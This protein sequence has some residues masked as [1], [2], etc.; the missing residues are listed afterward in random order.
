MGG[1]GRHDR[2]RI[3][4][5][6]ATDQFALFRFARHD[7]PFCNR[8]V[9]LV[10]PEFSRSFRSIQ[11]MASETVLGKNGANIAVVLNRSACLNRSDP[12]AKQ[13]KTDNGSG[14]KTGGYEHRNH[15]S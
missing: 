13:R 7:C 15:K 3:G 5:K 12:V 10:Q 2:V 8:F 4:R 6:N 9:A 1:G 14:K 11:T